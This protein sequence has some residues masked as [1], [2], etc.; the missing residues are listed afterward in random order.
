MNKKELKRDTILIFICS[1]NILITGATGSGKTFI[2]NALGHSACI[3][4]F[5]TAY[6]GMRKLLRMYKEAKVEMT[7]SKLVKT[8]EKKQL[9]ILDDLGLDPLD[10]PACRVLFELIDDRYG[11]SS[12]IVAS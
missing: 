2:A 11:K 1:E 9:F 3:G 4:G 7:V 8:I 12:T 6:F 10:K 5:S